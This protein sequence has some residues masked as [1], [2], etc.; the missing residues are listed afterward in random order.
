MNG[1]G[2]AVVEFSVFRVL[3]IGFSWP[4]RRHNQLSLFSA[5]GKL[6]GRWRL[7]CLS[8]HQQPTGGYFDCTLSVPQLNPKSKK[9]S[10]SLNFAIK[11]L[12]GKPI[13]K[14]QTTFCFQLLKKVGHR[15]KIGESSSKNYVCWL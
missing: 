5:I 6:V 12:L 10:L 14:P 4:A 1:K 7:S 2:H 13:K 11:I 15:V 9:R 3:A 8:K